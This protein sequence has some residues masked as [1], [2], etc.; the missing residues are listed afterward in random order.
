G[1]H[2]RVE[3]RV[4]ACGPTVTDMVANAALTL[5][6]SLALAPRMAAIIPAFPFEYVERNLYRAAK[7]G[8]H[9]QLAWR[10]ERAPSPRPIGARPLLLELLPLAAAALIEH[11]VDQAEAHGWLEIVRARAENGQTGSKTQQALGDPAAA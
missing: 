11:G 1:G 4:V 5:G 2:V 6:L 10:S 3:H 9:A 8:L 7:H